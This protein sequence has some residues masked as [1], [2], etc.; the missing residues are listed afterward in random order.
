M[1]KKAT[2]ASLEAEKQT[3]APAVTTDSET[4]AEAK[5]ENAPAVEVAESTKETATPKTART[6][7]TARSGKAKQIAE[8]TE[9]AKPAVS[10][11][12]KAERKKPGRKPMTAKQKAEA[13]RVRAEE[14]RKA[15]NLQP[16]IIVEY[17]GE[18]ADANAL[19]EQAK[20][21]FHAEKKRTL[22]TDLKLYVKPEERAAYYVINESY[23][24]KIDF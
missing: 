18:Q 12:K 5:E 24:G 21:A 20:A 13:A 10:D 23:T 4:V 22:I 19:V 8:D 14:K 9:K 2:A 7:R 1:S 15:D 3:Q 16:A 6:R 11:E 17:S